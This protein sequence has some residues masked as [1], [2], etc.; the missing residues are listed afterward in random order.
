M[1]G[2]YLTFFQNNTLS[3]QYINKKFSDTAV[4]LAIA[5]S[6]RCTQ[7]LPVVN[8]QGSNAGFLF[9]YHSATRDEKNGFTESQR[10]SQTGDKGHLCTPLFNFD[11][12]QMF[13]FARGQRYISL[14]FVPLSKASSNMSEIQAKGVTKAR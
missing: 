11:A 4:I 6:K 13:T 9:T 7:E 14:A 5:V 10:W 1:V 12:R 3:N 2:E 8:T